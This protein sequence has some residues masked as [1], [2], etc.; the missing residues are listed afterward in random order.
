MNFS[1]DDSRVFFSLKYQ[2]YPTFELDYGKVGLK[3]EISQHKFFYFGRKKY[4]VS[5]GQLSAN[6]NNYLDSIKES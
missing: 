6:D 5:Q 2:N 1:V 3:K 4:S